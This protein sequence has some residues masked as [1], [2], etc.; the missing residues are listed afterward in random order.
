VTISDDYIA[1]LNET[2]SNTSN[3]LIVHLRPPTGELVKV[4][5]RNFFADLMTD[6]ERQ[7]LSWYLRSYFQWPYEGF[8]ERAARAQLLLG[9]LGQRLYQS[10]F[11]TDDA[12]STF[13]T[14]RTQAKG[15]FV[16]ESGSVPAQDLPWE[17]LHDG[18]D[19]LALS[20]VNPVQIV[21]R[22]ADLL[23][24]RKSH[25]PITSL[26]VLLIASRPVDY[27]FIDPRLI[28]GTLLRSLAKAGAVGRVEIEL[29]RPPTLEYLKRRLEDTSHPVSIIHFDGHGDID[30]IENG[31]PSLAF[32]DQTGRADP[33]SAEVLAQVV[34]D[35]SVQAV[36]LNACWSARPGRFALSSGIPAQ[37]L[38]A[39]VEAVVAMGD[40]LLTSTAA[41]YARALY[42]SLATGEPLERAHA[43][44]R[45][46]LAT[47]PSRHR[48]RRGRAND[49]TNLQLSDWW[50][51][52][53]YQRATATRSAMLTQQAVQTQSQLRVDA[54]PDIDEAALDGRSKELLL[55][56][57]A[58]LQHRVVAVTGVI[59]AGK[60][61]LLR[62]CADWFV[63]THL[64][65]EARYVS[66]SDPDA[67]DQLNEVCLQFPCPPEPPDIPEPG[68]LTVT[69]TLVLID[70]VEES[71]F[72]AASTT[73]SGQHA[74]IAQ[75][76]LQLRRRGVDVVLASRDGALGGTPL[77]PDRD[78]IRCRLAGVDPEAAY[79]LAA[80]QLSKLGVEP[81]SVSYRTIRHV[82]ESSDNHPL[83]VPMAIRA[84]PE[85]FQ[86]ST[87]EP[88][89]SES[90][91]T[92]DTVFPEVVSMEATVYEAI[93]RLE[94]HH[95]QVLRS[96]AVFRHG[97]RETSILN[98]CAL[99]LRTWTPI[100]RVLERNGLA[101]F[102]P[103]HSHVGDV[104]VRLHP[105]LPAALRSGLDPLM[106]ARADSYERYYSRL[107]HFLYYER[108]KHPAASQEIAH[109]EMSNLLEAF[110]HILTSGD[111]DSAANLVEYLS[112]FLRAEGG[113]EELEDLRH[114]VS[115]AVET[116]GPLNEAEWL[117]EVGKAED[118][119]ESGQFR[120]ATVRLRA[121][122]SRIILEPPD[123]DY[124]TGSVVHCV[125][126]EML[127]KCHLADGQVVAAERFLRQS[128]A[129]A[130]ALVAA[131]GDDVERRDALGIYLQTSIY[132]GNALEHSGDGEAAEQKYM[133]V[134][135]VALEIEDFDHA[136]HALT[137]LGDYWSKQPSRSESAR[138]AY[139]L[140]L[141]F[142][143][144]A[145]AER[146]EAAILH[147]LATLA[148]RDGDLELAERLYR[149]SLTIDDRIGNES[150]VGVSYGAL[151]PLAV[152][153]GDYTEAIAWFR[154][155]LTLTSAQDPGGPSHTGALNSLA[156]ALM[157]SAAAGDLN[158]ADARTATL[159]EARS[160]GEE[161]VRYALASQDLAQ[162]WSKFYNLSNIAR[163]QGDVDS[164]KRYQRRT[165]EAF[166]ASSADR[167]RIR[168]DFKDVI[169]V[170]T[171]AANGEQEATRMLETII[172]E[173]ENTG[174]NLRQ[175]IGEIL[176]GRR[177]W[178][179]LAEDLDPEDALAVLVVLEELQGGT[180]DQ[181][182]STPTS[183]QVDDNQL[184]RRILAV[185]PE[186]ARDVVEQGEGNLELV[187]S[188]MTPEER[189][190]TQTALRALNG[191]GL[192]LMLAA[193]DQLIKGDDRN[194]AAIE[195]FFGP[196]DR[197]QSAVSAAVYSIIAG[198]RRRQ[199]LLGG[200]STLEAKLVDQ[201]LEVATFGIP[202]SPL[203]TD[204]I[205]RLRGGSTELGRDLNDLGVALLK[206]G[207][208]EAAE[209]FLNIAVH[210]TSQFLG[211]TH[212]DA[213]RD[214]RN[215]AASYSEQ[216]KLEK[217][218]EM[219]R[220]IVAL[221]EGA[222]NESKDG[223][224]SALEYLGDTFL[225][226]KDF[227]EAQRCYERALE[228]GRFSADG[229]TESRTVNIKSLATCYIQAEEYERAISFLERELPEMAR[230]SGDCSPTVRE[231]RGL[232]ARALE[233][234]S[235]WVNAG[236]LWQD[237]ASCCEASSDVDPIELPIYFGNIGRCCLNQRDLEGAEQ[238]C[239]RS[240]VMFSEVLGPFNSHSLSAG[241]NYAGILLEL[242]RD[243]EAA[244]LVYD[245]LDSIDTRNDSGR[246]V[247]LGAIDTL[248]GPFWHLGRYAIVEE[249][250]RKA[251][252]ICVDMYGASHPHTLE[253]LS[254]LYTICLTDGDRLGD[255]VV[256]LRRL[257]KERLNSGGEFE[258][259][260][261]D[262]EFLE[263]LLAATDQ[264]EEASYWRS[265]SARL[266]KGAIGDS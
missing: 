52:Q 224:R 169:D 170:V 31:Q 29:L 203:T 100:R 11:P 28:S 167:Q 112:P 76:L 119:S 262:M 82:L 151:G 208:P 154:R 188:T 194:V 122:L 40:V 19:F 25:A 35:T 137:D 199:K 261:S 141:E 251:E 143:R 49:V 246:S 131:A 147:S 222:A 89:I 219:W 23:E 239:H 103:L 240:L 114:R 238:A 105:L 56:E 232:L 214:M 187:L 266:R 233:S 91:S 5:Q 162:T 216:A 123:S 241:A 130:K 164:A 168:N 221:E 111:V 193:V 73:N 140:A 45:D 265:E 234:R 34:K 15:R 179:A 86:L 79:R 253:R 152:D 81:D 98:V 30:D 243:G 155:E 13:G 229:S 78:V 160:L 95:Q 102:E 121:L 21:R 212:P 181:A 145:S 196:F 42:T 71:A 54:L 255:A 148:R 247:A 226:Q 117:S 227:A 80:T 135:K 201:V 127:G 109:V 180:D 64:Y 264:A 7:L 107:G 173:L 161:A 44:A 202:Y 166:A 47:D 4:A 205:G 75:L 68:H 248:A 125:T 88:R 36:V 85:Y 126:M 61:S 256:Y 133:Q 259:L 96:L 191:H 24:T 174:W 63:R 176:A 195:A 200:L 104:Y 206:S 22:P 178:H 163:L 115:A 106:E 177:D 94:P 165:H 1:Y 231:R 249:L 110:D 99:S 57:R 67:R 132:H 184:N 69:Q 108:S 92:V 46:E 93:T 9:T 17:L 20:R 6:S 60:T 3:D 39:G 128:C 51:P 225:A 215:L 153:R 198:E 258:V 74:D 65:A 252:A 32:E 90:A 171:R 27:G 159:A 97:A 66:L 250:E 237:N 77:D 33:V 136:R 26:R 120:V 185:I 223:L 190:V 70:D 156:G 220:S 182:D 87:S 204:D 211:R 210:L 183:E 218:Q 10:L 62:E 207:Q 254:H 50:I 242:G 186:P 257:V 41:K 244:R 144:N 158:A 157:A 149:E 129:I 197:P 48:A 124:G 55:I 138:Q 172:S 101:A 213:L 16:I 58:L 37:L 12:K 236:R 59:G 83:A 2:G 260:V 263:Q 84:M 230:L 139:E 53:L 134:V 38:T 217:A 175:A 146:S 113:G 192:G 209:Y 235:D 8:A 189:E 18:D 14:W 118:L 228:L 150:G 116:H 72:V 142:A 43:F 245:I